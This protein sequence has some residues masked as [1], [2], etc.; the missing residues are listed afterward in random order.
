MPNPQ[1]MTKDMQDILDL[2][3]KRRKWPR[4]LAFII[5]AAVITAGGVWYFQPASGAKASVGFRSAK[6]F[7]GDLRVIVSAT[8]TLEPLSQVDVGTEVSG[9]IKTIKADFNDQV[10][11][12]QV[13]AVLD[14]TKL[15]ADRDAARASL[16]LAKAQLLSAQA[17][18][19]QAKLNLNRM[20]KA[21]KI[22]KGR[23]PSVQDVDAAQATYDKAAAQVAVY[24]A[25]VD[26]A[27][28][29]LV[30]Y[31][32]D[33][34]KAIIV[35]PID[36]VILNRQVENGQTVAASMS[37]PTLFTMA[38]NLTHMKLSISV[39]EADV[40]KVKEG[41]NATFVVD[42]YPDR[43]FPAKITQVRFAP[44]SEGDVVTYECIL[45]V[46]NSGLL[47]WPGMTATADISTKEVKD[48]LLVPNLAL[49]FTPPLPAE[50]SAAQ[51][52]K[53]D[54]G[55]IL[56][57]LM[58]RPRRH[59]NK[60]KK[61]VSNAKAG[62]NS[63]RKV[64]VLEN[65]RPVAKEVHVGDSDGVNTLIARGDLKAGDLVLIGQEANRK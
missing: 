21:F 33:L 1:E 40:G 36:G 42:A 53:K 29:S 11:K 62:Q 50:E 64:W 45:S 47:L 15:A 9:T 39:D 30:G 34:G 28:A 25:T 59:N 5:L 10:K 18:A 56:S 2:E 4:R 57:K 32:S 38:G 17:D 43:R 23:L 55:S 20:K 24:K 14:T 63:N 41:Q 6:A 49:R 37:T 54:G 60:Q 19:K 7:T 35:A 61:A 44:Q 46:D 3:E 12:G 8:G 13:L 26:K 22:S 31:E 16:N 48:A 65:G 51:P 58:P 27:A 52:K